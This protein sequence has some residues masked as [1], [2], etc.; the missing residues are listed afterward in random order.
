[1]NDPHS[2]NLAAAPNRPQSVG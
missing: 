2:E 1:M